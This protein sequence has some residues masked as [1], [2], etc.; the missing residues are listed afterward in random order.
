MK[1]R[2]IIS[3]LIFSLVPICGQASII[4]AKI[5]SVNAK[6]TMV[7]IKTKEARFMRK[8]QMVSLGNRCELEVLKNNKHSQQT[9]SKIKFYAKE[10]ELLSLQVM[11]KLQ[12]LIIVL[13]IQLLLHLRANAFQPIEPLKRRL[14]GVH[15]MDFELV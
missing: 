6:K 14:L 5:K 11:I 3:L 10:N 2:V 12:P 4:S 7:L 9:Q 8:G 13:Q 1:I 15:L